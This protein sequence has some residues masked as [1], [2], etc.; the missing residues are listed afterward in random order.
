[1]RGKGGDYMRLSDEAFALLEEQP[2]RDMTAGHKL[3]RLISGGVILGAETITDGDVVC[4]A[5]LYIVTESGK[6]TALEVGS[7]ESGGGIYMQAADIPAEAW[8]I[9]K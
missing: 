4:D 5:L 8:E 1:M 7:N 9:S 3:D 6:L 2:R